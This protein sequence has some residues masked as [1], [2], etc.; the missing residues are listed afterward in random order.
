MDQRLSHL[1]LHQGHQRAPCRVILPLG[2]RHKRPQGSC[3]PY[4]RPE[5]R[6]RRNRHGSH[7]RRTRPLHNLPRHS[8]LGSCLLY[9]RL[10]YSLPQHIPPGSLPR[11]SH[12]RSRLQR[13]RLP[14]SLPQHNR[15]DSRLQRTRLLHSL[16]QHSCPGTVLLHVRSSL[17][18]TV[19]AARKIRHTHQP[20]S[21]LP[22]AC[23]RGWKA[24]ESQMQ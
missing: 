18:R 8:R 22:L 24:L 7:P 6:P 2:F 17:V 20:S 12:L 3:L 11:H 15:L 21:C 9:T 5:H 14:H 4:T 23:R 10:L 13:T 19:L 1:Y 16:P